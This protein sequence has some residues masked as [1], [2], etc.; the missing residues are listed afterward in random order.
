MKMFKAIGASF[1]IVG[2]LVVM[3]A[4]M[5][6]LPVLLIWGVNTLFDKEISYTV[7]HL[8][9]AFAIIVAVRGGK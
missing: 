2:V 1:G 9:G 5:C 8:V 7:W 6:I 4:F 3:L